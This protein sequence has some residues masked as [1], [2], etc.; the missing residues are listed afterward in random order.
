M[1]INEIE[2][3]KKNQ[4]NQR[5]CM[6]KFN[7]VDTFLTRLTERKKERKHK[8]QISQLMKRHHYRP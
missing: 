7:K 8:L 1:E 6:S 4:S 3:R 5:L 2:N